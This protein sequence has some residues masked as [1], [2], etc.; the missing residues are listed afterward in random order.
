MI[1]L[2]LAACSSAALTLVLKW[3]RDPKGSRYVIIL[4]NYLTC[5][6]IAFIQMPDKGHFYAA[7]P[8][9]YLMSAIGGFLYIAGLVSMQQSVRQNGAFLMAFFYAFSSEA[10]S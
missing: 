2:L 6:L 3:F 5:V 10:H 8:A 4:G 1:Y 9:T 7:S